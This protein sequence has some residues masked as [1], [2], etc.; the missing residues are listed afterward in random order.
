VQAMGDA[1]IPIKDVGPES[2]IK[3]I[4]LINPDSGKFEGDV[5]IHVIAISSG[6]LWCSSYTCPIVF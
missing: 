4:K 5:R 1:I 6:F 2:E 3:T